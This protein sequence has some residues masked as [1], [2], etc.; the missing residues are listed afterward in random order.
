MDAG[1]QLSATQ[2]TSGLGLPVDAGRQ[3]S[4]TQP[5]RGTGA[6][7]GSGGGNSS[8]RS[9]G[10]DY[11]SSSMPGVSASAPAV[12]TTPAYVSAHVAP[13]TFAS[14]SASTAAAA[15]APGG[16]A[17]S[18]EYVARLEE[19][20]ASLRRSIAGLTDPLQHAAAGGMGTAFH[21][22]EAAS[23]AP[24]GQSAA[25]VTKSAAAAASERESD[26]GASTLADHLAAASRVNA[27][28]YRGQ[29]RAA[30][31]TAGE[32]QAAEDLAVARAIFSDDRLAAFEA[33]LEAKFA[34]GGYDSDLDLDDLG[35]R[36]SEMHGA[37]AAQRQAERA[38]QRAVEDAERAALLA[39]FEEQ[40]AWMD[41][42]RQRIAADAD[43]A[44]DVYSRGYAGRNGEGPAGLSNGGDRVGATP[45]YVE[46]QVTRGCDGGGRGGPSSSG[47]DHAGEQVSLYHSDGETE[48]EEAQSA[49]R[50]SV[51]GARTR[52]AARPASAPRFRHTVR[53][54]GAEM[55]GG[56]SNMR[57]QYTGP[58]LHGDGL[59]RPTAI[60]RTAATTTTPRPFSFEVRESRRVKSI[61]ETRLEQDLAIEAEIHQAEMA[62]PFRANPLPRSTVEPR[63]QRMLEREEMRRDERRASRRAALLESERPFTFH[64]RAE[65]VRRYTAETA[66]DRA[67]RRANKFQRTFKAKEVPRDVATPKL[68]EMQERDRRRKEE[69]RAAAVA[70]LAEA[71]LP[72]RMEMWDRRDR[73]DRRKP[74]QPI[75]GGDSGLLLVNSRQPGASQP[76]SGGGGGPRPSSAPASNK[77]K[78][79]TWSFKPTPAK[80]V[81]DFDALHVAFS[82]RLQVA[83]GH[84]PVTAV[85]EFH[86]HEKQGSARD[87]ERRR[88]EADIDHDANHLPENRWPFASLR[89]KVNSTPPPAF[90]PPSAAFLR[91]SD[92]L[93]TKLRRQAVLKQRAAGHFADRTE[94]E[95]RAEV[96]R[97]RDARRRAAAW[98]Q[99]QSKIAASKG[100]GETGGL[101]A[102]MDG[103]DS[104]FGNSNVPAAG[105]ESVVG[106]SG[107]GGGG[108]GGEQHRAA[109]HHQQEELARQ[110]V[111]KVLL[112]NKIYTYIE[113][114]SV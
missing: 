31:A 62:R 110:A 63:Y 44:D 27:Q 1:R 96:E 30:A 48:L 54:G 86:L 9:F 5:I 102:G 18:A 19:E 26:R 95:A 89:A 38:D 47:A 58:G 74:G 22:T 43:A 88:V 68:A 114:G 85:R 28:G 25:V 98:A 94:K 82:R 108:G 36:E 40:N 87:E 106:A 12:S 57:M 51:V 56:G 20:L 41:E 93:A 109:R 66:D 65:E 55:G 4:A 35:A 97:R 104:N 81:P 7:S 71:R 33:A 90:A 16:A 113:E 52:P 78:Q 17:L 72:E 92:T 67:A 6:G 103:L 24:R 10:S 61:S 21:W 105:R 23:A 32:R 73:E 50:R 84:R 91:E 8:A 83:R 14:A 101:D 34:G 100:L 77:A 69:A 2:P 39:G 42:Y 11:S 79:K 49:A 80:E 70:K 111:A 107:G 76:T 53:G 37:N 29:D 15:V 112:E 99:A 60:L 75:S 46:A 45:R 64:H 3:L 13:T 59:L